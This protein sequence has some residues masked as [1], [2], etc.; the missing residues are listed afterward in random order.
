MKVSNNPLGSDHILMFIRSTSVVP[1]LR[2]RSPRWKLAEADWALCTEACS[3]NYHSFAD[4]NLEGDT[5]YVTERIVQAATITISQTNFLDVPPCGGTRHAQSQGKSRTE[6]G[7]SL[8]G[9]P[10]LQTLFHLGKKRHMPGGRVVRLKDNP[11]MRTC[12]L[13]QVSCLLKCFGIEFIKREVPTV[14]SLCPSLVSL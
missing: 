13:Y 14:T 10:P 11:G 5:A 9:T 12:F 8:G 3:L 7:E 6:Y 1:S 2:P 4:L